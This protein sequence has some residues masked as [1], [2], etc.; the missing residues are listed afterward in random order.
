M[1]QTLTHNPS[2]SLPLKRADPGNEFTSERKK[3]SYKLR[4]C[5]YFSQILK[6]NRVRGS[7]QSGFLL[8]N[9]RAKV[10]IFSTGTCV[11]RVL[12]ETETCRS[13]SSKMRRRD[14]RD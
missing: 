9:R 5:C 4:V 1:K 11:L 3:M 7:A 10:W 2:L 8:G 6:I 12:I 13:L 14:K